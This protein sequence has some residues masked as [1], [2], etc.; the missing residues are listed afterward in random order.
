MKTIAFLLVTALG[1]GQN[2]QLEQG[3]KAIRGR[4]GCYLV[5]YS[6]VEAEALKLGYTK[7][8]RVYDVNLNKSVKEWII[9]TEISPTRIKLQHVLQGVD[10]KGQP[11][12]GGII[13]HTGEDWEFNA[14]LLFDYQGQNT[15]TAK[16]LTGTPNLWVRRV[17]S[18]DDGLRYQCAAAWSTDTEYA[19]WKCDGLAPIPG[20]EFRDMKRKDYQD[21]DRSSKLVVYDSNWLE[22]EQNTK[23]IDEA[24]V[25]TALAKELGKTWYVRLPDSECK[26]AQDF[27]KSRMLFWDFTRE[28]WDE[29]LKEA[30]TWVDAKT[31]KGQPSRYEQIS[32]LEET[33]IL[34][35]LKQQENR[36]AAKAAVKKIIE[37]TQTRK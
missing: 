27:A 36:E 28:A 12:P 34:K 15:W 5:D 29:E 14:P 10:L 17:T 11:M 26:D 16:D 21:L 31:P 13:H 30:R 33:W 1:F 19:S 18:L 3:K 8:N 2:L 32:D 35:D 37:D 4:T 22:R 24:G 7:D 20:R 9:A 6:F 25:K 23:I